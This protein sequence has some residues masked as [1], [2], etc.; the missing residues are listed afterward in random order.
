MAKKYKFILCNEELNRNGRQLSLDGCDLQPFLNNPLMYYNHD[1]WDSKPIGRWE[2]VKVEIINGRKCLTGEAVF[3]LSD[4]LGAEIARKVENNFIR[5]ASLSYFIGNDELLSKNG[6]SYLKVLQWQPREASIVDLPANLY[7]LRLGN[8]AVA[9]SLKNQKV[10]DVIDSQPLLV[11][12]SGTAPTTAQTTAQTT[13][14]TVSTPPL[15]SK[16]MTIN[17]SF[18]GLLARLGINKVTTQDDK[19]VLDDQSMTSIAK[20]VNELQT[21]FDKMK[22]DLEAEKTA[23]DALQTDKTRLETEL[24]TAK[25]DLATAK[26][27]TDDLETQ[28]TKLSSNPVQPAADALKEDGLPVQSD[29]MKTLM[30]LPHNQKI[31]GNDNGFTINVTQTKTT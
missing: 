6:K 13:T 24:T 17:L 12:D 11:A 30:A 4:E 31:L 1:I 21:E 8:D 16:T 9:G 15:K 14:Q 28:L 18:Q 23:K 26:T 7:A 22:K 25:K 3:D 29:A 27:K 19:V 5:A 20:Q 10:T 2:N